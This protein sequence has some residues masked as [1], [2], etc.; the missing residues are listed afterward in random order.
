MVR[1]QKQICAI[2][3][4]YQRP[5]ELDLVFHPLHYPCELVRSRIEEC[6]QLSRSHPDLLRET[7][8]HVAFPAAVYQKQMD[9]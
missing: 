8:R 3:E 6:W 5:C 1:H 7:N 4:S 2:E 9:D